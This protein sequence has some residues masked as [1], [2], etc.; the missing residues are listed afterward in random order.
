MTNTE[1]VKKP[2][3]AGFFIALG[4]LLPFLTGQLQSLGNALLPMQFRTDCRLYP[5]RTFRA[6]Y[7]FHFTGAAQ[8]FVWYAAHLPRR[9]F[10]EL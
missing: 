8:C 9:C 2:V 10:H 3:L 1:K 4:L 6:Y 5:G 7:R